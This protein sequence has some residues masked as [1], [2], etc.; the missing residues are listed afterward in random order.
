MKGWA[1]VA[2][3]RRLL[4]EV[5][6]P[7]YAADARIRKIV[8]VGCES[9]TARYERD[10]FRGREYWTVD[11]DRTHS[12]HSGKRHLVARLEQLGQHFAPGTID[13]II[14]NGVYGWGLDRLEDCEAALSQCH[15]CL[16]DEG[17]LLLGWN[18]VPKWDPAPLS[19]VTSLSLFREYVFPPLGVSRYL[20][21]TTY[22]HTYNFY[23]KT[24]S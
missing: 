6:F 16:V 17:Q 12:R 8:F 22:R 1:K 11:P 14:C 2:E 24:A 4:E 20:T 19:A 9:Y 7:H 15:E 5:I 23:R 21:N 3:D 10:H 18:D 13:L